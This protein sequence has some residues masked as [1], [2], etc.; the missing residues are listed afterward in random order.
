M[1]IPI[2]EL[3][4]S[5]PVRGVVHLGA[6]E[7]EERSDYLLHWGVDDARTL[8]LEA[9]PDKVDTMTQRI[10]GLR[11]YNICLSNVDGQEVAFMV[12][13]NGQ[14]SSLLNFG[15]HKQEHPH[16]VET[17]RVRMKTKTL[18]T[19]FKEQGF[20]AEDFNFLN[21][22]LQGAELLA[23]QGAT[24]VLPHMDFVYTEVN[25]REVYENC[26]LVP[27]VDAFLARYGF[28]RV[29]T[30]MTGHGWGDALYVRP[31]SAHDPAS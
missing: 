25:E 6:H 15:L 10:P 28:K 30:R 14:S 16:V 1:L 4:I 19:F 24:D 13:N 26:A 31:S 22:D 29:Q 27:E 2:P 11:M 20:R 9:L 7:C 18:N 21:V 8:W 3:S 5:T 12:A 17:Q 23:F